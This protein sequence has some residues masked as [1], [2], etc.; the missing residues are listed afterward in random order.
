[1]LTAADV[2]NLQLLLRDGLEGLRSIGAFRSITLHQWEEESEADDFG[3]KTPEFNDATID[4]AVLSYTTKQIVA[5]A[6]LI[7]DRDLR[8][9]SETIITK[10]DRVTID[11]S[12]YYVIM[13][14]TYPLGDMTIYD[15]QVRKH[16]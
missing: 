8:V 6:G 3:H 11:G 14:K 2:L 15:C 16:V 5:A 12:L 9:L 7:E 4:A 1:M 13:I 10:Q